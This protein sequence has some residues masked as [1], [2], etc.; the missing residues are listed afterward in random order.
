GGPA[1]GRLLMMA[2][3]AL[4]MV[5]L[6]GAGLLLESFWRLQRVDPGFRPDHLLTMQLWLPKTKYPEAQ[7]VRGF[8]DQVVR[9]IEGLPGV[10]AAGAV[11]FRPFL[12]MGM[13]TRLDIEGRAPQGPD[14]ILNVAYRVVTPGYLY[15]LGQPLITGRDLE[16]GDG[17]DSA[18]VAV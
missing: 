16:D 11:S 2:E 1:A 18:G 12:G 9:R 6:I 3:I 17:P 5:L 4:S 7:G 14:D 15:L 8:W 10:R 13:N